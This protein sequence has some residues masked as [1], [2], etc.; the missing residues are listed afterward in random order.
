MNEQYSYDPLIAQKLAE[1]PVPDMADAIWAGIDAHLK[2]DPPQDSSNTP[3]KPSGGLNT[4]G[5]VIT[6]VAV[7]V[8]TAL[9][10]WLNSGNKNQKNNIVPPQQE[11]KPLQRDS[12][13]DDSVVQQPV[14]KKTP[15]IPAPTSIFPDE[16]L[17]KPDSLINHP[18]PS[19]VIPALQDT[20]KNFTLPIPNQPKLPLLTPDTTK[21][22]GKGVKG[23][24]DSDY[25][26]LLK[27]DSGRNK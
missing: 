9:V 21:P 3:P 16:P 5:W 24:S 8:V 15:V 2:N 7:V 13:T 26:L 6:G 18:A 12:I 10:I 22:K 4:I 1:L 19:I 27:N 20:T 14:M 11:I 23:L 17:L 25:K